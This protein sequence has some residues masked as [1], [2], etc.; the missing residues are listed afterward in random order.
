MKRLPID[1]SRAEIISAIRGNQVT[2]ILGA[3]GSGK[4]T[5]IPIMLYEAGF[6]A[7]G[8]NV[9]ARIVL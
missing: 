8:M 6:A 3:T 1:D 4:T 9:S 7:R 2:V 5:Q